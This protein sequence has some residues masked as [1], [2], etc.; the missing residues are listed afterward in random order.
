MLYFRWVQ[1]HVNSYD[2]KPAFG[3]VDLIDLHIASCGNSEF[4]DFAGS[5]RKKRITVLVTCSG[6][7]F[8]KDQ[9]IIFLG[10][11]IYFSEFTEMKIPLF[12]LISVI[13]KILHSNV[14]SQ[15]SPFFVVDFIPPL[16]ISRNFF[17]LE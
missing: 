13:P 1:P 12:D 17:L 6:L 10:N 14:F 5:D 2:I 7:Y 15:S 9:F 3:I 11:H 16:I 4:F 8:D